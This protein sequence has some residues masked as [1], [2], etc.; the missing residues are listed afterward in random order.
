MLSIFSIIFIEERFDM[1]VV[2]ITD[3][4]I[5]FHIKFDLVRNEYLFYLKIFAINIR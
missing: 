5:G 1:R 4:F 2:F 3:V